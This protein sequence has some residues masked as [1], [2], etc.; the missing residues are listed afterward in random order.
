DHLEWCHPPLEITNRTH[1]TTPSRHAADSLPRALLSGALAANTR[2]GGVLPR[3][4]SRSTVGR[5]TTLERGYDS[6]DRS[7]PGGPGPPPQLRPKFADLPVEFRERAGVVHHDG[8]D[9]EALLP[10]SLRSH[11]RLRLGPGHAPLAG[12]PLYLDARRHVHHHDLVE[13]V[14]EMVLCQ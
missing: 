2:G 13:P 6:P 10:G 3:A 4:S 11:P 1:G 7:A 14:R 9:R 8:G 5:V 12:Q